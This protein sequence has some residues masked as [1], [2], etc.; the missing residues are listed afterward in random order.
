[1]SKLRDVLRE[2]NFLFV[3]L[4][5]IISQFGD[6]FAMMALVGL[7]SQRAPGSAYELAKLSL[8][9]SRVYIV[10]VGPKNGQ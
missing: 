10:I 1:M 2:P 4:G 3:W 9:L 5:Q 7:V 8:A 6:K